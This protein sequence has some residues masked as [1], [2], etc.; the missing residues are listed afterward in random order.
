MHFVVLSGSDKW[1]SVKGL[2]R[3]SALIHISRYHSLKKCEPHSTLS[4]VWNVRGIPHENDKNKES[5]HLLSTLCQWS[6]TWGDDDFH[7]GLICPFNKQP[8]SLRAVVSWSPSDWAKHSVAWSVVD[9]SRL[10]Q[11]SGMS[12]PVA[13]LQK[14]LGPSCIIEFWLF[15]SPRASLAYTDD[16]RSF[17]FKAI[18]TSLRCRI[19]TCTSNTLLWLYSQVHQE[20]VPGQDQSQYTEGRG[21]AVQPWAGWGG[22][23]EHAGS[24]HLAGCHSGLLQQSCHQGMFLIAELVWRVPTSPFSKTAEALQIQKGFCVSESALLLLTGSACW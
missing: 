13:L 6:F 19:H 1:I 23:A 5:C 22:F 2:S 21:A 16:V 3:Y 17:P 14:R 11:L 10:P 8:C 9:S 4:L 20:P 18:W 12:H 15:L 24:A 7:R